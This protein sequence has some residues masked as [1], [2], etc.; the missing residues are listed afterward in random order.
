M[1]DT[2]ASP[3]SPKWKE[4]LGIY[5]GGLSFLTAAF[6]KFTALEVFVTVAAL[7]SILLVLLLFFAEISVRSLV[8]GAAIQYSMLSA[9]VMP[10]FGAFQPRFWAFIGLYSIAW[11]VFLFF[12]IEMERRSSPRGE[13][14]SAGPAALGMIWLMCI[15]VGGIVR[16]IWSLVSPDA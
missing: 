14:D 16:G 7:Y 3:S 11:W 4:D 10:L 2:Q 9:L 1:T 5:V 8:S 6:S 12:V 13:I 15:P